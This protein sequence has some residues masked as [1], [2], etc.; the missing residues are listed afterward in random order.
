MEYNE[1][2][3]AIRNTFVEVLMCSGADE[4]TEASRRMADWMGMD[5]T[6]VDNLIEELEQFRLRS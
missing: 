4:A 5:P 6:M 1:G 3:K 2:A